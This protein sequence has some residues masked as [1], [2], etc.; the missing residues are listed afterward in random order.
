DNN[1]VE[2]IS[3]LTGL[4]E[5]QLLKGFKQAMDDALPEGW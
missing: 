4:L 1:G 5:Q 3:G 2:G